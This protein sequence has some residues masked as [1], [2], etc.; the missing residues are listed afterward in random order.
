MPV[1]SSAVVFLRSW[2]SLPLIFLSACGAGSDSNRDAGT[3]AEASGG[4]TTASGSDGGDGTGGGT[5]AGATTGGTDDPADTSGDDGGAIVVEPDLEPE[6]VAC[7]V[8]L[9]DCPEG[10]KCVAYSAGGADT[11]NDTICSPVD[12]NPGQVGDPCFTGAE[13]NDNCDFGLMCWNADPMGS[14]T[15][16]EMCSGSPTNPRCSDP[17]TACAISSDGI[18]I[19]CVPGCDPILQD[20]PEGQGCYTLDMEAFECV[21]DG[22]G[23]GGAYGDPCFYGNECD[24]G[25][26]CTNTEFVPECATPQGCCSEFCDITNPEGDAQCMGASGGQRCLPAYPSNPPPGNEHIGLCLIPT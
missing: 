23:P 4:D 1:D 25:L 24:P 11:W 13:G 8:W 19:L 9:Q 10:Q 18:L 26:F 21:T 16:T 20:C 17:T 12:E 7:D 15:C 6:G 14:G 5:D 3:G 22:S 2:F